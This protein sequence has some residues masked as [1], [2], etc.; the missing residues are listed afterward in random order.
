M[1]RDLAVF[2]MLGLAM[3]TPAFARDAPSRPGVDAPEL[4]RLGHFQVGVKTMTLVDA[5]QVD[6]LAWDPATGTAPK[7][8]R[9]LVV[10]LWYPADVAVGAAPETYSG[11]L[12]AEPPAPP[13]HFTIPGIA[14]R[15]APPATG[16]FP[17]V[18][19]SHGYSNAA[20]AFSWLTENLAS[21]G[22]VVAA[23]RHEDPPITDRG[24]FA[25][26]LL[27][28]PL[29]IAFVTRT[30]QR[31]LADEGR[32]DPS[33]TALIGYSMGGYGVLTVGGG[34]LDPGSPLS[35]IIPGD[36][37][38]PYARGGAASEVLRAPGIKAIVAFAP[39]GGSLRAWG[40]EGLGAITAPLMLIAGDRDWTVD[41]QT[42][43]R[44]F[45]DMAT[46]SP[47]YLLTYRGAGHRIALGPAPEEMRGRLW[48]FDWFED[49]VWRQ[50][51]IIA[52]NLHMITA[53]LDRYIK[54][55]ASR[56]PYLDR[57]TRESTQGDWPASAARAYDAYSPGADGITVW[58]GFQRGHA[59]GLELL[60]Q[61]PR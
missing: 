54:D 55:D 38:A 17:L 3:A 52:I 20:I 10:D 31:T 27:R 36:L 16:R 5:A 28:R 23:I 22:Y 7:R 45:F 43:A 58:K 57:L 12:P 24:K 18:V 21:K 11:T 32:I 1:P 25:E 29:D 41:Y 9:V 42:G 8:D 2:F 53:F 14:V 15:D 13:S 50:D 33:R 49:P 61:V 60:H 48:D 6:V 56:A 35:G 26:P 4:A 46:N 37:L 51:R 30:L 40:A 34:V 44:A 59:E 39:G 47:R 19:V